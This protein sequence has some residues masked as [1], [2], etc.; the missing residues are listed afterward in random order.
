MQR[1]LGIVAALGLIVIPLLAASQF[2]SSGA[3]SREGFV[4]NLEV[5]SKGAPKSMAVDYRT[6]FV[7]EGHDARRSGKRR[8]R[9]SG[10]RGGERVFDGDH[11]R[12]EA[13][14]AI[15]RV[16]CRPGRSHVANR[17]HQSF[18]DPAHLAAGAMRPPGRRHAPLPR[19]ARPSCATAPKVAK[20]GSG[21]PQRRC[22]I[23]PGARYPRRRIYVSAGRAL[24]HL[25]DVNCL[26]I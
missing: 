14:Q 18:R 17:H 13:A 6:W 24:A 19:R 2:P 23:A 26:V 8:R 9:Q 3:R 21:L 12:A 4:G 20:L 11:R 25:R 1:S 7:P 22:E 10:G 16:F 15:W 5:M